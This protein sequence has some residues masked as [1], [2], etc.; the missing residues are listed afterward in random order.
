MILSK[1]LM[2]KWT[3]RFC[4]WHLEGGFELADRA[5]FGSVYLAATEHW[6]DGADVRFTIPKSELLRFSHQVPTWRV[7][8]EIHGVLQEV[9]EP[10]I[11]GIAC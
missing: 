2:I 9:Y 10:N 7:R 5:G 6:I 4:C 11:G 8:K 1:F 3:T